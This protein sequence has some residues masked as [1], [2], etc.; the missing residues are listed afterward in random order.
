MKFFVWLLMAALFVTA[1]NAQHIRVNGDVKTRAEVPIQ[2]VLVMAFDNSS[3]LKS[4][5]SNDKGEY[6]F[7]VD[8]VVFDIVYYKPGLQ[9]HAYSVR[10]RLDKETQGVYVY[11]QMDDS[12]AE[13]A[14]NLSVWLKKHHISTA[15][16]D[17]VFT[18]EVAKDSAA[19]ANRPMSHKQLL[20]EAIA[21]QKRFSNYKKTTDKES[22]NNEEDEV[23][24]V[25]IGTDKYELIKNNK[26]DKRYF[27][28]DKPITEVTYRFE[29][30]RRYDGVLKNSKSVKKF[31]KYKPSQHVKG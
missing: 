5:V 24:R 8:R 4:Y 25:T 28:N 13:T 19:R 1:A 16:M 9:T 18:Q 14:T 3:P 6:G 27:K 23:T 7:F 30:T 26:G 2:G 22:V 31:D 29:T 12:L 20:K 10:N 17:S 11:I 21:E 15:F